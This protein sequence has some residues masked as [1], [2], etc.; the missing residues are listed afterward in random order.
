[1]SANFVL[2]AALVWGT[3]LFTSSARAQGASVGVG[4]AAELSGR[5]VSTEHVTFTN[6]SLAGSSFFLDIVIAK[7]GTFQGVWDAYI[8]NSYPG[9]YSTMII[10]CSRAKKPAK[11]RGK[12]RLAAGKGEIEL[13]RLG[14][15]SFTYTLGPKL[16]LELPKD[17]LKQGD[18]VLFTSQLERKSKPGTDAQV[19]GHAGATV[20]LR[21]ADKRAI[22]HPTKRFIYAVTRPDGLNVSL[23]NMY[24][25]LTDFTFASDAFPLNVRC[26]LLSPG[27]PDLLPL[28]ATRV[29]ENDYRIEWLDAPPSAGYVKIVKY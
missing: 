23:R 26:A 22:K 14:R 12:L 20:M 28:L 6:P 29:G 15:S 27:S 25:H 19:P 21:E 4:L 11:A 13:E 10:S 18:P 7:D 2:V 5:W 1:M 24:G 17:W 8:C 16:S 9:A 3:M